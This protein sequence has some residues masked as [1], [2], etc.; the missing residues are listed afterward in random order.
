[1]RYAV[2]P[3]HLSPASRALWRRILVEASFRFQAHHLEQLAILCE[4]RD[5]AAEC[6]AI[7]DAE[8]PFVD[9]RPHGALAVEREAQRTALRALTALRLDA[10]PPA[11]KPGHKLAGGVYR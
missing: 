9:G 2:A 8:P 5:R 11:A 1:M 3:A 4:S 6:R 7:L 10:E